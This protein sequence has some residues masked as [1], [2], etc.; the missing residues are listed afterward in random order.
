MIMK[1]PAEIKKGLTYCTTGPCP[2]E[3][4]PYYNYESSCCSYS[5]S[6]DALA[7]IQ[8][9]E[10]ALEQAQLKP[11]V[12]EELQTVENDRAL[13]LEVKG[14][15]YWSHLWGE[16]AKAVTHGYY[17]KRE[18]GHIFRYWPDRKPTEEE[19]KAAEWM[20]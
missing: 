11:L 20:D 19:R 7:Y 13:Y 18:Y 14:L 4:C 10:Q 1:T 5:K 3:E 15:D 8:Q 17:A 12:L 2:G 6:K 16:E 9:L